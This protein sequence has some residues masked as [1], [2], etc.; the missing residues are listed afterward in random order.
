M[1]QKVYPVADIDPGD[2]TPTPVY[3]QIDDVYYPN[4]N[5][6]VTSGAETDGDTFV[7]DLGFATWPENRL[8]PF[9]L[10]V[11]LCKTEQ[12]DLPV[13]VRLFS[14]DGLIAVRVIEPTESFKTYC[15]R[16]TEAEAFFIEDYLSL[17]LAVSVGNPVQVACCP[18]KLPAVLTA[19]ITDKTGTCSCMPD[20]IQLI[21][22][23]AF[24]QW[25]SNPVPGCPAECGGVGIPFGCFGESIDDF[26]LENVS[27]EEGSSCSP[28]HLVFRTSTATGDYRATITE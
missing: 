19:T 27:P 13:I 23:P 28:L 1:S 2:F 17:T 21:W 10:R 11:R 14:T 5:T 26:L 25:R 15:L 3:A 12:G 16:L 24:S 22:N 18:Q 4:D 7:V 8:L 20:E 6:F 9:T